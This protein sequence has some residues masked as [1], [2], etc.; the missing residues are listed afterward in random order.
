[1]KEITTDD[2]ENAAKALSTNPNVWIKIGTLLYKWM[3]A[4]SPL[5]NDETD[6]RKQDLIRYNR[7]CALY[8]S[9]LK[10]TVIPIHWQLKDG[11]PTHSS[12][13][14]GSA[15]YFRVRADEMR[16]SSYQMKTV[17]VKTLGSIERLYESLSKRAYTPYE[18][19]RYRQDGYE[20]MFFADLAQW[21]SSDL[22]AASITEQ[23]TADMLQDRIDFCKKVQNTV[24]IFRDDSGINNPKDKL[25]R[26]I[27]NLETLHKDICKAIEAASFNHQIDH[28]ER[29]LI[30]MAE[31]AFSICHLILEGVNQK[32]LQVDEILDPHPVDRKVRA[33]T[34]LTM[35]QWLRVTLKTLG[36][37]S[38]N[39]QNGGNIIDLDTIA[40]HLNLDFHQ[41]ILNRTGLHEFIRENPGKTDQENSKFSE[42]I[43][44]DVIEIHR[45]ILRIY[46][47][48]S[49]LVYAARVGVSLGES[50]L[51]GN[52]DGKLV[53]KAL[54]AVIQDACYQFEETIKNFWVV[55][56]QKTY[57]PYA[58]SKGLDYRD[59]TYKF[60][61]TANERFGRIET[62]HRDV[63]KLLAL[64]AEKAKKFADDAEVTKQSKRILISNLYNFLRR[65]ANADINLVNGLQRLEAIENT[66]VVT[67]STVIAI[68]PLLIEPY[69]VR[70][71]IAQLPIYQLTEELLVQ[72]VVLQ[73]Q[74]HLLTLLP[75]PARFHTKM[76]EHIYNDILVPWH[77][78][79]NKNVISAWFYSITTFSI[80][81]LRN[82]Y[83]RINM[84]MTQLYNPETLER[85]NQDRPAEGIVDEESVFFRLQKGTVTPWTTE[86][87]M[88][89]QHF[90]IELYHFGKKFKD[91]PIFGPIISVNDFEILQIKILGENVEISIDERLLSFA[92]G[93]FAIEME[94]MR[95]KM[96]E[97]EAVNTRLLS[98]NARLIDEIKKLSEASKE[99]DE[100]LRQTDIDL[101]RQDEAI[102]QLQQQCKVFEACSAAAAAAPAASA[103]TDPNRMFS[104]QNN[105]TDTANRNGLNLS[106]K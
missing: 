51:Y 64:I 90:K 25:G 55:F 8:T 46:Y 66:P 67:H 44:K 60:L 7:M 58:T 79:V 84:I 41:I 105:S 100:K 69:I 26:I 65:K 45:E 19:K 97:L 99:K 39:F 13:L 59:Q 21:L 49:S 52:E 80:H 33:L 17:I 9:I 71:P 6:E 78:V 75:R 104:P 47:V 31:N 15:E 28:I 83:S 4:P 82:F 18:W 77:E 63:K 2:L 42:K 53:I 35:G 36:I 20:A 91:N 34:E 103:S 40:N 29:N 106:I 3:T 74:H 94:K 1:M 70:F 12:E 22:P 11:C 92:G 38:N 37:T 86:L 14:S 89:D 5:S 10:K 50:W 73:P 32:E 48:K 57:E 102:S 81:D 54:L 23:T 85:A 76:Q 68:T 16:V 98:E 95:K 56:Y 72:K 93:A 101:K 96:A 62:C 87:M 43:L 24:F 27:K 61:Y 30:D 88:V